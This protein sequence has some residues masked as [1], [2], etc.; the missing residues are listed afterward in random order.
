M[1]EAP[2]PVHAA[3]D[4]VHATRDPDG[5]ARPKTTDT[6]IITFSEIISALSFAIDLTEDAVPGHALRSCLLGMRI[7]RALGMPARELEALY[8]A[9][10]LK[11]VGCSNHG[12]RLEHRMRGDQRRE[13]G[14]A[15]DPRRSRSRGAREVLKLFQE[16]TRGE[17]PLRR[18]FRRLLHMR[19]LERRSDQEMILLRCER[20]ANITRKLGLSAATCEAVFALDE[21][22]DGAGA[23]LQ[24]R[25][26]AI[27][28]LARIVT[29]AEHLDA[30]ACEGVP[31][32]A[33]D[34]MG[35]QSG[36][37]FDPELVEVAFA[38]NRAGQLWTDCLPTDDLD[39]CRRL[40]IGLDPK[41]SDGVGADEIDRI[42]EAFA[43][44]VDAKSPFT[45]R[46]SVGVAQ[47]AVSMGTT[48]ALPPDRLR[49]V[50]RAALLHDLGKLAVPNAI[51][52][53]SDRLSPEEWHAVVEH[54]RL[55]QQILARIEPF[56]ELAAIAGAHHEKLDGSGYPNGLREHQL[57]IESRV[58]AVAD[59][60]RAMTE[61]RPYRPGVSH[62][63]AVGKLR[64]L[65]PHQ[66]DARCVE[67]LNLC[68]DPA[69]GVP[70]PALED[71]ARLRKRPGSVPA[72]GAWQA[73]TA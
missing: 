34:R 73:F 50:Q 38:L 22:W 31:T 28:L 16:E 1:H 6:V 61:G 70:A 30:F 51:L 21:R 24:L 63:V 36:R 42:C 48:L 11:D 14:A 20:G 65:T 43:D 55:T 58:I 49:M 57:G 35:E 60:Y 54:P 10:L 23:P 27:P 25:A 19:P 67:A 72:G 8:Y 4:P 18:K 2:E 46:H 9:L 39:L 17:A 26:Q 66:L 47:V 7:A 68:C 69:R 45:Y 41:A 5:H 32:R 33:I 56:A 44:V 52:D 40:V 53:K 37:W 12:L 62:A 13:N 29:L 15:T 64:E 71:L 59:T 3:Q